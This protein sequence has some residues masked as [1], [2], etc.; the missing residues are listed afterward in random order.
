MDQL[1]LTVYRSSAAR[2]RNENHLTVA[3]NLANLEK[4]PQT[5]DELIFECSQKAGSNNHE[6][7][8]L[9]N[10]SEQMSQFTEDAFLLEQTQVIPVI[11]H[12]IFQQDLKIQKL[13]Q[14]RLKN[15]KFVMK[16]ALEEEIKFLNANMEEK[17]HEKE[18]KQANKLDIYDDQLFASSMDEDDGE[19]DSEYQGEAVDSTNGDSGGEGF[20]YQT[21]K[22][23]RGHDSGTGDLSSLSTKRKGFECKLCGKRLKTQ[24]LLEKHLANTFHRTGLNENQKLFDGSERSANYRSKLSLISKDISYNPETKRWNCLICQKDFIKERNVY[25]H[26]NIV[27]RGEKKAMCALCGKQFSDKAY[28]TRHMKIHTG[29]KDY[30]CEHC[31]KAFRWQA[32]VNEHKSRCHKELWAVERAEMDRQKALKKQATDQRKLDIKKYDVKGGSWICVFWMF[33]LNF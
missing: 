1:I 10:L 5:V 13:I 15:K 3:D 23:K 26:I 19:D 14:E 27:H 30:K 16:Q 17:L 6:D 11:G 31:G 8:Q 18:D 21:R 32:K 12:P 9:Q 24:Y 7:F 25:K 2:D 20:G 33:S 28:L 22:Q 29:R 4:D